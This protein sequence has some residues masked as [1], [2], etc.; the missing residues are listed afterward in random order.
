M[1]GSVLGAAV[2]DPVGELAGVGIEQ[3]DRTDRAR[4]A[5]QLH[6]HEDRDRAG[7]ISANVSVSDRATVMAGLAKLVLLV[8]QY[9]AVR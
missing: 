6:E 1:V 2:R 5:K 8:N 3:Q 7:A 9:A 4:A